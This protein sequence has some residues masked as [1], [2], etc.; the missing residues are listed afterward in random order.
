MVEKALFSQQT[1]ETLD[2]AVADNRASLTHTMSY[3]SNA[4]EPSKTFY[5]GELRLKT[6][7]TSKTNIFASIL[8]NDPSLYYISMKNAPK[9]R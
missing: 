4:R 3:V 7:L 2:F 6:G 8:K 5:E 9:D 1:Q